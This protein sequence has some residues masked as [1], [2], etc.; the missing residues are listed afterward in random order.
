MAGS[1]DIMQGTFA[2]MQRVR[3][4]HESVVSKVI[5]GMKADPRLASVEPSSLD[6]LKQVVALARSGKLVP[7]PVEVRAAS[8]VNRSMEELRDGKVIGRVVLD[9]EHADPDRLN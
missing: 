1:S 5:A 4:L 7:S 6:E 3:T 2:R 9:F 8:E